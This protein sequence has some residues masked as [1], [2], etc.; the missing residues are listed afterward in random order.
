M[1]AKDDR[2]KAGESSSWA[3]IDPDGI[4]ADESYWG[5]GA[6]PVV[7]RF[8]REKYD[9]STMPP[10]E[11]SKRADGSLWLLGWRN[12]GAHEDWPSLVLLLADELPSAKA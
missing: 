7:I 12:V 2:L 9:P 1:D 5:R 3:K 6:E 4:R 10:L 8:L 11:L